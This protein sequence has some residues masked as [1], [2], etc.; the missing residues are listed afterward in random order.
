MP[1]RRL[2]DRLRMAL[3]VAKGMQALEEADPP[4]LHRD[5]K[6]SNVFVDAR[7]RAKVADFGLARLLTPGVWESTKC[8]YT[9]IVYIL[10]G[11][12]RR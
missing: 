3:D 6:P 11:A 12:L 2:A 5:L 7:G 1:Q 8:E 10:Q 4:V 9:T